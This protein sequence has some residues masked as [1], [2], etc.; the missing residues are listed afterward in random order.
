VIFW[1]VDDLEGFWVSFEGL[2]VFGVESFQDS[3]DSIRL[4]AFPLGVDRIF[5]LP[6]SLFSFSVQIV[7]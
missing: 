3:A 6:A 2:A 4:A 5:G 1:D 7:K